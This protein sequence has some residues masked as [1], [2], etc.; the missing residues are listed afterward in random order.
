MV[1]SSLPFQNIP[2]ASSYEQA[3]DYLY[4]LFWTRYINRDVHIRPHFNFTSLER[5]SADGLALIG[6]RY[7]VLHEVPSRLDPPLSIVM[8]WL[9][10]RVL[11]ISAPNVV[12]YSP[13]AAVFASDLTGELHLMR[14]REFNPR[15]TVV[16]SLRDRPGVPVASSLSPIA[17]AS[18]RIERQKLYFSATSVGARSLVVLPFRFS[19]CWVPAWQSPA[20][21]VMRVDFALLGVLFDGHVDMTFTWS[22]GYGPGTR[23]L[24]QDAE[25]VP[26]ASLAAARVP[27]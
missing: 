15:R 3:L 18:I 17:G 21:R 1:L 10:F 19:H 2:V 24:R 14:A 23:C 5:A 16:L 9:D 27:F 13:S 22:A 4:Y 7:L 12:G 20:G 8:S 25:L 26:E 11:E 6:V